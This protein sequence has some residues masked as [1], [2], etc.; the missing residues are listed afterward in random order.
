M[1]LRILLAS[2]F[3]PPFIGG[4]ERQVQLLGKQLTGR[5]HTV[6]V[7]TVWHAGLLEQED[8]ASTSVY[9]LKG[10]I[11]RVPWFS[12]DPKRRF[13]PP[14]PDPAV[15]LA[16]R[17]LISSFKPD[18]VHASGWIAY[19]CVVALLGKPIPM[20]L[21]VRDYGYTCAIRTLLRDGR[22]CDG[23]ALE[24]CMRCTTQSYGPVKALGA[25]AG[26][27]LGRN[28]LLRKVTAFHSVSTF[29]QAN[30]KDQLLRYGRVDTPSEV[31]PSFREDGPPDVPGDPL[32][33]PLPVEPFILFVGAL[34]KYKGLE[35]LLAAYRQLI[36]APPLVLIGTVWPETPKQF[37]PG[38]IVL[39][40]V[41]HP[42]VMKA[43]TRSLFGIAPSIWPEPLGN[44]IFE[45]MSQGKAVVAT[46][47][48]G[49][50]DMVVQNETG[51]LVPPRDAN[52]LAQAMRQLIDNPELRERLG[53]AAKERAR[54]FTADV[55]VPR[56]EALYRRLIESRQQAKP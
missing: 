13:H 14:F 25:V 24:K 15:V 52:A 36:S 4:A 6:R 11:T 33:D 39:R 55:V 34:Q 42:T 10:L 9:R 5:G 19:S 29:V 20:L 35:V 27:F 12:K 44:V 46:N 41:P 56:F 22:I 53:N 1:G 31:I 43:W 26:I 18:L 17:R 7:A 3:Y 23:P 38:V 51:L 49:S 45:A 16:L 48:G 32:E 28:L 47:V 2:D 21:S 30:V 54:L 40:N 50:V 37:P 8:D